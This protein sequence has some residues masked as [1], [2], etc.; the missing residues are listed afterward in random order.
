MEAKDNEKKKT[1]QQLLLNDDFCFIC[2]EEGSLVCC[3]GCPNS[4]HG[5]RSFLFFRNLAKCLGKSFRA[6]D[7]TFFCSICDTR[8]CMINPSTATIIEGNKAPK[9]AEVESWIISNPGFIKW[10]DAIK[11]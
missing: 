8:V 4:V 2:G 11:Q 7:P 9:K 3:D 1:Y 6:S 5:M 10:A